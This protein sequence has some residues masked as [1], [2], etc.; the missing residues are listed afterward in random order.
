MIHLIHIL[1]AATLAAQPAPS[2]P[3][4]APRPEQPA[5]EPAKADPI[6]A[7]LT[8]IEAADRGITTLAGDLSYLRADLALGDFQIRT[9]TIAFVS[10]KGP[11]QD[12]QQ[13]RAKPRR[14]FAVRFEKYIDAANITDERQD[15]GFDGQWL[16]EKNYRSKSFVQRQI[17]RE[18]DNIDPLRLGEGPLPLPIGQAKADIL[19]RYTPTIPEPTEGLEELLDDNDND[20]AAQYRAA[21]TQTN[22][23]QLHLVPL[24][25][26]PNGFD[27]IRLWYIRA[28][29]GQGGETLLP[30]LART[31]KQSRTG[32]ELDVAFV[33]LSSLRINDPAVTAESIRIPPPPGDERWRVDVQPL[34]HQ[35]PNE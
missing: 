7:L 26:D 4:P 21:V 20:V 18:G 19:A 15:W 34:D 1:L 14:V 22:A 29:D 12:A 11:A 10:A 31:A 28:N 3:T 35:P 8:E 9:G 24:Q 25:E 17:A 30:L 13:P 27:D 2:E 33:L 5:A 16:T 32:E 23:I 6:D